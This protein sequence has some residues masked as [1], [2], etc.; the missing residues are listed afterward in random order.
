[1]TQTMVQCNTTLCGAQRSPAPREEQ[2]H[3]AIISSVYF[4]GLRNAERVM[5]ELMIRCP[6]TG[7]SVSTGIFMDRTKFRSMPVFFSTSYCASCSSSHEWFARDAWMCEAG[8]EAMDSS[9]ALQVA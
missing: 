4:T 1:M 3:T 8:T 6:N 9:H 2:L 7:K 5:G